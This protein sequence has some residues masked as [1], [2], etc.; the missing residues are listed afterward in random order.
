MQ[1]R[2]EEVLVE[3]A[4]WLHEQ[5][6]ERVLTMAGGTALNCVANS[7]IWRDTKFDEV[8][9]QPAAGDAGTSLGAALQVLEPACAAMWTHV[10]ASDARCVRRQVDEDR[11]QCQG[12]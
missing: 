2:L 11:L 9:V 10:A 4:T 6:G 1:H 3:L 5:T 7:R 8:W 12:L